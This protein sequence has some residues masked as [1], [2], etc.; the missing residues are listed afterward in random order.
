MERAFTG[1]RDRDRIGSTEFSIET[2][3]QRRPFR[4]LSE[5]LVVD[6][7]T[8]LETRCSSTAQGCPQVRNRI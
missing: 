5:S 6:E 4:S 8:A 2:W 3:R 1:K 7:I